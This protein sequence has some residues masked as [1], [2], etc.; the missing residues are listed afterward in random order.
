MRII[1]FASAVTAASIVSGCATTP[2]PNY[3]PISTKEQYMTSVAGSSIN[4]GDKSSTT[5]HSDGTMTGNA[6]DR[7]IIGTW[8]WEDGLFC[9][10]G[11]IG[12]E[13]L[14]RDCQKMEIAGDQL[15][16]TRGD[17]SI[18]LFTLKQ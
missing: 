7:K 16:I 12:D 4:L 8:S 11:K 6:G 2:V 17:G 14:K 10:E 18:G 5:T 9:R 3:Q 1:F 13:D 15:R